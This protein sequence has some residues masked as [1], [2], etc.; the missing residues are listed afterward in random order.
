MLLI[1][2]CIMHFCN[3]VTYCL[4]KFILSVSWTLFMCSV[5]EKRSIH[6]SDF[7]RTLMHCDLYF[8][9]L[10]SFIDMLSILHL[11]LWCIFYLCTYYCVL[12]Y[13]FLFTCLWPCHVPCCIVVLL[14][15]VSYMH[16]ACCIP[17]F[18]CR[19]FASL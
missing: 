14:T 10:L 9:L 2:F 11:L 3:Q 12:L 4:S 8:H 7:S 5:W 15:D 16:I 17:A 18:S 1:F 19:C 13:L 6:T